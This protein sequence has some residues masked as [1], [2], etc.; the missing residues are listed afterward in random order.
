VRRGSIGRRADIVRLLVLG[1]SRAAAAV[2]SFGAATLL[3]RALPPEALGTWALALA[4]QGYALHLGELGLRS[5]ITAAAAREPGRVRAYIGVRRGRS[6]SPGP[7][8]PAIA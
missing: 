1:G 5:V 6:T 4:V 2:L 7:R 8:R 3:A